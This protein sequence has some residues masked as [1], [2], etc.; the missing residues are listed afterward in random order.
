MEKWEAYDPRIYDCH[1]QTR[2]LF[3]NNFRCEI[4]LPYKLDIPKWPEDGMK[5]IS[6]TIT[7]I[8]IADDDGRNKYNSLLFSLNWNGN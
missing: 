7:S 3:R 5:S 1:D 2:R 6:E 4:D 8:F